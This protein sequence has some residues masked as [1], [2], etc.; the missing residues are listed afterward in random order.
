M[1]HLHSQ[2][3]QEVV[4]HST[5]TSCTP[6]DFRGVEYAVIVFDTATNLTSIKFEVTNAIEGGNAVPHTDQA[7]VNADWRAHLVAAVTVASNQAV[8]LPRD[9]V[10]SHYIRITTAQAAVNATARLMLTG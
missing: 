5:N 1:S 7:E 2:R 8:A 10:G 6:I 4:V 3:V 9:L